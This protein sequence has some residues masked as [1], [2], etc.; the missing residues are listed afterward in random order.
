MLSGSYD[1][2]LRLWD[3]RA[4]TTILTMDH[5]AP[6]EAILMFPSGGTCLSAGMQ[7]HFWRP[8]LSQYKTP[9]HI[10]LST[11]LILR[12]GEGKRALLDGRGQS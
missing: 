9:S 8:F 11:D 5:G 12:V 4:G 3:L 10:I 2:T 1:H 6:V 7:T